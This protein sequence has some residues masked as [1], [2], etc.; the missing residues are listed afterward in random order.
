V[1]LIFEHYDAVGQ[2]RATEADTPVDASGYLADTD[3][4]GNVNGV[5]E[6]APKLAAS[7]EVR[8]CVVRQWFRYAF[9][10]SESPEDACTLDA[11]DQAFASTRGNLRE[12]LISITQTAPFLAASP[13]PEPEE[14]P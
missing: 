5:L 8:R 2:Y 14:T 9:G 6:L 4:A 13:A 10:R 7:A 1:G 3:V 12:L 11:L